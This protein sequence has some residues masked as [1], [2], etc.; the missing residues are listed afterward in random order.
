MIENVDPKTI[1]GFIVRDFEDTWDALAGIPSARNRGNFMFALQAMVLLEWAARL[2]ASDKSGK[3]IS[4]FS[5]ALHKIEPRYFTI[6]PF[7]APSPWS[8][9]FEL[10]S[11]TTSNPARQLIWT[12]FDVV[13]HGQA[14][15]YQ[16]IPV[17][18]LDGKAFWIALSGAAL[19]FQLAR[20]QSRR[21]E[22][23]GYKNDP[24]GN[25]VL[26]VRTDLMFLDLKNAVEQSSLLGRGLS[27]GYLYRPRKS[28]HYQCDSVA[29]KGA[30]AAG[31]HL[32]NQI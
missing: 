7:D 11:V 10:P 27:F 25:V 13:R 29:L 24:S 32:V 30:L 16:Q 28:S 8:R 12:L 23:L 21:K 1:F 19:G 14:H 20:A 26:L 5:T 3:A 2:A 4:A 31:G 17:E 6:L 18:L 22:H 15:Q 9:E